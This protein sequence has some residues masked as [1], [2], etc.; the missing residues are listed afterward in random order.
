MPHVL[1]CGDAAS[2]AASLAAREKQPVHLCYVDPP[3]NVGASFAAR[4]K[5]SETR[6]RTTRESGPAAYEDRWGGLDGF[7][8]FLEPNVA[9][10][11]SVLHERGQF[12]LHLDYR[13]VH[14]AKVLCDRV[15]GRQAFRGEVIWL[16]GNGARGHRGP[17]A[18]HQTILIY[19]RSVAAQP[20]LVW[21]ADH[22]TLRESFAAG[23]LETHFRHVD[24]AGRKYRDR[25]VNGKTYRYFADEGRRL[26]SVWTDLPAMVA[27][28]PLLRE[29]TGYPTQKP[30]RLLERII[31]L[32]TIAGDT[33]CDPMCGS[34]TT[35]VVA[36]K[37]GRRFLGNDASPLAFEIA[38][39]R[40]REAGLEFSAA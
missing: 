25:T 14:D 35:L 5:K 1:A 8:A 28:T 20:D 21:N 37:L 24:E 38:S 27:N 13:A 15:F 32:A 9:A 2:F 22:P 31:R 34:G 16:P 4:T 36:G 6:G 11:R 39:K 29:G 30:E 12:W 7:L 23:S 17:P 19:T 33:V 18:T 40:L 10:I 26:G 3:F